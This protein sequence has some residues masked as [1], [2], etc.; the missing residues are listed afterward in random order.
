MPE[1]LLQNVPGNIKCILQIL[2]SLQLILPSSV[3]IQ[4]LR[5]IMPQPHSQ[6]P[7][8]LVDRKNHTSI[9]YFNWYYYHHIRG[10][11]SS[12]FHSYVEKCL[13]VKNCNDKIIFIH[14]TSS[15][16][17]VLTKVHD[18]LFVPIALPQGDVNNGM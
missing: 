7:L 16:I 9:F 17:C 6:N 13:T 11:F 15:D 8:G 1:N 4:T 2:V 18:V 5:Q 3:F 10:C 12:P 14:S